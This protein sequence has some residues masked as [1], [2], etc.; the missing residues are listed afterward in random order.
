MKKR[1]RIQDRTPYLWIRLLFDPI[2]LIRAGS[3]YI[4]FFKDWV[5]YSSLDGAEQ[6]KIADTYP[7]IHGKTKTTDFNGHYF[8]QDIWA[9][10]KIYESKV[11]HHVDIGSRVDFVGFLTAITRVTSI[12]I[13]PLMANLENL[14]SMKENILSMPFENNSV[15]SLSCL[16]VA[17]HIGLGRYGDPLDPHGTKKA[18]RELARILAIGGNLY[19]SLPVGHP[20]LRFNA[21]RIHSPQ[22]IIE[23]CNGL[24]LVELSG[25]NDEGNFIK[26]IE[27]A[28]LEN[29]DYACGLFHFTKKKDMLLLVDLTKNKT[30]NRVLES[31]VFYESLDFSLKFIL[32]QFLRV[33]LRTSSYFLLFHNFLDPGR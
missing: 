20:R 11:D 6:I 29:S 14:H 8:Y 1:V 28:V 26:N 33:N 27:V 19:F 21:H 3:G 17:E 25:I 5:K 18:C 31:A 24:Q 22:Q 12:D 16:H 15:P 9:F 13:R 32:S 4:G 23:Y 10:K 2:Q 7:C 30:R